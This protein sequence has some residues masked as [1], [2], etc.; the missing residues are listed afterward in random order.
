MSGLTTERVTERVTE[1]M[2]LD[3]LNRRYDKPLSMGTSAQ[4]T[5]AEHVPTGLAFS[6]SSIADYIAVGM[7]SKSAGYNVSAAERWWIEAPVIHGHEVKVSRSDWL[8]ELRQP[9]KS[10]AWRSVSHFW[11]L[12]VSD[13]SIVR[14]DLPEGWGLMVRSGHS[15]RV[16][17]QAPPNL[18]AQ[19]LSPSMAGALLR[20]TAKT[21]RLAPT[22]TTGDLS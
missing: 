9:G 11:W 20:A 16:L 13:K 7:H 12:V 21:E 17:V 14:D 4:F 18:T 22:T 15:L 2:M 19:P 3:A 6:R 10:E 5:R 8:A 1:R